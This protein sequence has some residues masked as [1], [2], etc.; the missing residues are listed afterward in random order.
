MTSVPLSAEITVLQSTMHHVRS[1]MST[2]S[3]ERV[4][5]DSLAN[6]KNLS[7]TLDHACTL[8]KEI[9]LLGVMTPIRLLL[10]DKTEA[11]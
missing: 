11:A 2:V 9:K 5:V 3:A 10:G 7:A 8:C 4:K 6:E 1:E